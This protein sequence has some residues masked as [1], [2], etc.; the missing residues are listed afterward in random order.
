MTPFAELMTTTLGPA[1]AA[2]F[3]AQPFVR[4]LLPRTSAAA[5][6]HLEGTRHAA[7]IR[8]AARE[9]REI[10]EHVERAGGIELPH[11]LAL[12]D[13]LERAADRFPLP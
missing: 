12:A 10:V 11:L 8:R 6:A 2:A 1:R 9:T 4:H 13:Y 3:R 7:S 5:A